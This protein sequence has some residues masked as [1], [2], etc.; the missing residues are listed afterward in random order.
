MERKTSSTFWKLETKWAGGDWLGDPRKSG[1]TSAVRKAEGTGLQCRNLKRHR[2]WQ[3]PGL[4]CTLRHKTTG[5]HEWIECGT[6]TMESYSALK[7][8]D[9]SSCEKTL[10]KL[11]S[12]LLSGR[13]QSD[14]ATYCMVPTNVTSWKKWNYGNIKK[15]TGCPALWERVEMKM[16]YTGDFY[17][18]GTTLNE[19]I[20]VDMCLLY[21]CPNP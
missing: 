7:R 21:I 20:M 6:S 9:L 8:N 1:P 17:G 15:I 19:T 13:G 4:P 5:H 11:K 18:G 12:I 16:G 10:R 2:S 3:Y 14:K